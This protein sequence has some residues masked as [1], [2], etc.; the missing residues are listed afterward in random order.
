MWS[1]RDTH[2]DCLGYTTYVTVLANVC[3]H[4]D[5]APLTL[6]IFGPWGSGKT[7]LMRMLMRRIEET[8][9]HKKH[10]TLWFNAWMYEG[11]EEA[12]SALIHAVLANLQKRATL[13]DEVT[14]LINKLKDGTSVMKLGKFI[15]KSAITMTP[16]IAG[17]ADCFKD[18][19]C[20][21]HGVFRRGFRK[22]PEARRHRADLSFLSMTW[23]AVP[24][25]KSSRHSRPSNSS[26]NTP[27]CT[28]VVG[29]DAKRFSRR[30]AK[31]TKSAT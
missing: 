16:D 28:F 19:S 29:A 27:A 17:F 10:E 6:G 7:S 24:A 12:Q 22:T 18:E 13:G 26:V 4:P 3:T 30:S 15:M 21:H 23:I 20:R 2:Q 1:D 14:Q 25:P 31:S 9:E 8:K 5:L 11:R